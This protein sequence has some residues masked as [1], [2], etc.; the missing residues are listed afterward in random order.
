M[1]VVITEYEVPTPN[2]RMPHMAPKAIAKATP[3]PMTNARTG[4][5]RCHSAERES[6]F[7]PHSGQRSSD[8]RPASE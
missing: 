7:K 8:G 3:P 5:L 4:R 1:S 2:D 6:Y